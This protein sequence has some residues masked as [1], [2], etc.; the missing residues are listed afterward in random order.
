MQTSD[1]SV[2]GAAPIDHP[3]AVAAETAVFVALLKDADLDTPVPGC[4]GWTLT[5]LARHT[6]SVQRW[7]SVLLNGRI[8]EPPL[9]RDV[10]LALPERA[11][12]YADWL[13][14]SAAVAAE[15]FAAGDPAAPMWAWGADQH[16]RFWARRMHMETLLHRVDAEV[17]LGLTPRID[18]AAAVDGVAEFLTNLPFAT[19]FAPKV[20]ELR[21]TGE[22]IRFRCTDGDEEWLVGLR[23]DGFGL[24][25]AEPGQV[26]AQAEVAGAAA[27]LL[28]LVYGRLDRQAEAFSCEGDD[29]LLAH[30]VTNSEF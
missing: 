7:F 29:A 5:D 20:A 3:A 14:A 25:S 18:R 6:G 13:A 9:T 30:W 21:G 12:G 10:E 26:A 28:L 19:R 16:A 27:D 24:E 17:A 4:P 15:A 11:D 22:A 2:P 23:P 1:H 8:Q